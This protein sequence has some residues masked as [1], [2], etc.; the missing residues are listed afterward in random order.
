M[1]IIF[2]EENG[3]LFGSTKIIGIGKRQPKLIYGEQAKKLR[4]GA[5][6]TI[7]QLA[8]EFDVR[9]NIIKK[10]ESQQMMLDEKMYNKYMDKFNINKEYF[11][12]LDLETL[13]LSG[14]G[15]ILKTFET[16][17]ECKKVYEK[18]MVDYFYGIENN[19][20]I[21]IVDFEKLERGNE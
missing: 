14:E 13:I 2:K 4:E 19:A 16:S 5:N 8:N 12:D 9:I 3:K 20:K 7:E 10:I 17:E 15:H 18:I 1:E 6:L 11:F 21:F